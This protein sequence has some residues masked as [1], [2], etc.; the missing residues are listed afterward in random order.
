MP[1]VFRVEHTKAVK[2]F[3]KTVLIFARTFYYYCRSYVTQEDQHTL[4]QKWAHEVLD[5]L[6]FELRVL[7][8]PDQTQKNLILVG[9]HISYLDI[10]VL[11]AVFP[12]VVFL[13]KSEVRRFPIIGAAAKRVGTLF[14]QR[15]SRESKAQARIEIQRLLE[16]S[17]ACYKI[18]VFP[19]GTTTLNEELPWKTGIFKIAKQTNTLIQPFKIF[20][21]PKREC[22]YIDQDNLFVGLIQLFKEPNKKIE[23]NWGSS[24]KISDDDLEYQ[25]EGVRKWTQEKDDFP[26]QAGQKRFYLRTPARPSAGLRSPQIKCLKLFCKE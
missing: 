18:A 25:I 1:I 9:N 5:H 19:S 26:E 3:T 15:H 14:V 4:K 7:G 24:F 2:A 17:E 21:S 6:G 13:A 8:S 11:F 10:I 12:E 22:A 23:F 20:Y 16:Q